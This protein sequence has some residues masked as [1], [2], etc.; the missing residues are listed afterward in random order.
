MQ[1]RID[2]YEKTADPEGNRTTKQS[3]EVARIEMIEERWETLLGLIRICLS[4][5]LSRGR[6]RLTP[7]WLLVLLRRHT[8]QQIQ[9]Q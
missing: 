1:D 4:F 2:E 5:L 6:R 3:L 7:D 8:R 9:L